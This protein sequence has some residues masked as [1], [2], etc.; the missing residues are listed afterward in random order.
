MVETIGGQAVI[1]GVMLRSSN[2]CVVAVR[3]NGKILTKVDKVSPL[4]CQKIP[5]FRGILALVDMLI[6]GINSLLWSAAQAEGEDFSK[7]EVASLLATTIILS[8]L[9]FIGLP[10]AVTVF[11]SPDNGIFFNIIDG[12]LRLGL[13]IGYVGVISRME[14]ARRLFRFHGA[15]HK[16]VNCYENA[17]EPT[18]H[19]TLEAAKKCSVLHPRCGTTFV[20]VILLL[21]AIVFSI[22]NP[23]YW[24]GKLLVRVIGLPIIAGSSYEIIKL[25]SSANKMNKNI[26]SSIIPKFIIT[27]G[28]WFQR[29]TTSEPAPEELEVGVAAI[30]ALMEK[31]HA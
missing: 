9:F 19:I 12:S 30:N 24:L 11:I 2:Y 1:D 20:M 6:L 22:I 5:V 26:L 10:L 29:M 21:S 31:K 3:K 23:S 7:K 15:E 27:P 13:F 16:V 17:R 8:L 25:A 18:R 28:F 14:D 4:R